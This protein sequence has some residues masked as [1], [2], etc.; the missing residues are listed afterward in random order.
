[1]ARRPR[2]S[3]WRVPGLPA[4]EFAEG[5]GAV[6]TATAPHFHAEGQLI[7]LLDGAREVETDRGLRRLSAGEALWIAPDTIHSTRPA[8]GSAG[9]NAHFLYAYVPAALFASLARLSDSHHE[10]LLTGRVEETRRL[11]DCLRQER[12]ERAAL[13][14]LG[15]LLEL[16][17]EEE[18]EPQ[19]GDDALSRAR[20][21]LDQHFAD[22][23]TL[24]A[25][26]EAAGLS[27]FHLVRAFARRYGLTPHAWLLRR[28]VN[29]AK[30]L[31]RA[32]LSPAEAAQAC[33][34][35]D[36]SHLGL[37]FRRL[38]GMT[39]AAYRRC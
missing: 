8:P 27:R 33:G 21:F 17:E 34:F 13:D 10:A 16:G 32:G 7:L 6:A 18:P 2:F 14:I 37:Y 39:P 12:Q 28:R 20:A 22:P 25:V 4:L 38:V 31:L 23:L 29:H 30:T 35:A 1:M 15:R 26:A 5:E 19:P 11:V 3:Y 24:D 9:Q 36:Q